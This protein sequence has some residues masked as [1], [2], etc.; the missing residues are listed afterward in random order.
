MQLP[1]QTLLKLLTLLPLK[2][3]IQIKV[4][5]DAD[6]VKDI[7]IDKNLY[8]LIRYKSTDSFEIDLIKEGFSIYLARILN[9][10]KYSKY[11]HF[12]D[13][14]VSIN[15]N[16]LSEFNESDVLLEELKKFLN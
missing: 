2:D 3:K 16:I 10:E 5:Y 9:K 8:N 1:Q 15:K 6:N 7:H 12:S 4:R 13:I 14:G 11:I